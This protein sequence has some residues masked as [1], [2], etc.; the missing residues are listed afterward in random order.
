MERHEFPGLAR[1][2]EVHAAFATD[3]TAM[4]RSYRSGGTVTAE[5]LY[6]F[7]TSW[8][9]DHVEKLD[10]LLADFLRADAQGALE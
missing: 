1:Q 5:Q 6:E 10:R 2:R 9:T 7:L 8:L 3:V 4:V